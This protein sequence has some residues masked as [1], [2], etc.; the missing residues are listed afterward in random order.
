MT[1]RYFEL[2]LYVGKIHMQPF[3]SQHRDT[4]SLSGWLFA[5]LLLALAVMFLVISPVGSLVHAPVIN[6]PTSTM[7]PSAANTLA[8][9]TATPPST[10]TPTLT[11]SLVPQL[12]STARV[13]LD[14]T[15]VLISVF[16][17]P[18]DILG[19]RPETLGTLRKQIEG[20]LRNYTGRRAGL[21]ITLGYHDASN[22][23]VR[24]SVI[25]NDL[26]K[27]SFPQI[28]QDSLMK[29][30]WYSPMSGSPQGTIVF[31]IYFFTTIYS[32]E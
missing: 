20:Q 28:F 8:T 15:P 9:S 13:G 16:A 2:L 29:E 30:F 31:E 19:R 6:T 23:G 27:S 21:V 24:M 22:Q 4:I 32:T 3:K 17:P 18:A 26:L 14:L 7:K 25:G 12:Q 11:P 1:L 5:D 10:T